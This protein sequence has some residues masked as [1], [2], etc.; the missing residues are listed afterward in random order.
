MVN[1]LFE[2]KEPHQSGRI[3]IRLR[4]QE[5]SPQK[6]KRD[7]DRPIENGL[8]LGQHSNLMINISIYNQIMLRVLI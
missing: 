1:P 5:H 6:Q 2:Q 3:K 4:R 8:P 7:P